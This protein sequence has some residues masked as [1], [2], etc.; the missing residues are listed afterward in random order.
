MLLLGLLILLVATAE[1]VDF[2]K[3][4]ILVEVQRLRVVF[5]QE[6]VKFGVVLGEGLHGALGHAEVVL[7]TDVAA[8]DLVVADHGLLHV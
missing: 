3:I 8:V 5:F 2:G 6:L 7:I 4:R 1:L